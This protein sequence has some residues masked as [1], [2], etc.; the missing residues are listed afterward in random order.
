MLLVHNERT[1]LT[2]A[3]LNAVST[4]LIAAGG[5]APS[6]AWL[7]GISALPVSAINVAGIAVSCVAAGVTLHGA[8]LALLG[9]LRE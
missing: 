5:F 6:A 8:G 9:S 7:Y 1:K 4:A 3:W 2:A